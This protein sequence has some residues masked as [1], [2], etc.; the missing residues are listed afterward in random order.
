MTRWQQR[1]LQPKAANP[2]PHGEK[3]RPGRQTTGLLPGSGTVLKATWQAFD[4]GHRTRS[5]YLRSHSS[6]HR[7]QPLNLNSIPRRAARWGVRDEDLVHV[8]LLQRRH[9]TP[10]GVYFANRTM[11]AFVL[12]EAVGDHGTGQDEERV[13]QCGIDL[14]SAAFSA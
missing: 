5:E 3:A 8:W 4:I 9:I 10:N 12:P 7:R 2:I 1:P 11:P 13:G 14:N 6:F